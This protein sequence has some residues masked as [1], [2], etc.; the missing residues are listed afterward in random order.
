MQELLL[1]W[2]LIGLTRVSRIWD[3]FLG[4]CAQIYDRVGD[5]I[6][7]SESNEDSASA[8]GVSAMVYRDVAAA[9]AHQR[10]RVE[11]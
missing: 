2:V 4:N 5:A 10:A 3:I 8:Y 7:S 6:G 1:S 9:V 11:S